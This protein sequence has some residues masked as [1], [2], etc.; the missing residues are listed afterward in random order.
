MENEHQSGRILTLRSLAD[1]AQR[2]DTTRRRLLNAWS[3]QFDSESNGKLL[4]TPVEH[5][6][7]QLA[8]DGMD[9]VRAEIC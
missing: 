6:E 2:G 7:S 3:G 8:Q 4:A 5:L 1:F 9:T